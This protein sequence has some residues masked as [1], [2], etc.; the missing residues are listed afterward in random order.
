MYSE[1]K[2]FEKNQINQPA[3]G[4][5]RR[6][7]AIGA[8]AGFV[9]LSL[10]NL[11]F[12]SLSMAAQPKKGGKL[13][14]AGSYLNS[15][16]KSLKNAKHPYYG[17]E[18]RTR[19]TYNALTWVDE[20]LN[21][22]PE[23]A[24]DWESNQGQDVWEVTIREDVKFHDGRPLT[25]EDVIA[26]YNLHKD[27]KL[28]TSFVKK[29]VDKIEKVS[30]NKVRFFLKSP[31]SEFAWNLAEY[32]QAIM[33][34]AP[35]DEMGFLGI[36]SGPY[37]FAKIDV[38]RRV[39]YEA[40]EDYWGKGPYLDTLE[41]VNLPGTNPLNGYLSGQFDVLAAVDP[42]LINQL[43]ATPNTKIDIAKAGDQIMM[44]LPKYEGSPF[45]DKRVRQALTLALDREAIIRIVFGGKTGW[46]SND[47][48]MAPF[49]EDFL[50]KEPRNIPKA[51]QLLAEAGFENGIT[52]PTFYYAPYVPEITRVLSV[53]AESVKEAGITMKI[54]ERPMA[55]YRKW[56]VE[57]K[58][59]TTKHR[60]AMGPVG[61]RNPAMNLFRMARPTYNESGYWHPSAEGD[62]Y[63]E[64]YEKAMRT[65]DPI[66]RRNI[67]HD[68]QRILQNDVPA[69]FL[70][71]RRET[72][73]F[74]SNVHGLK[75]HSQH[76]S[77]RFNEVWKS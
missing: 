73:A 70:T 32:R 57:N 47:T 22:V 15:K 2:N 30:T 37:K 41:C 69:I 46:A 25:V 16:H 66:A 53:A 7:F 18:I 34:A 14:Y 4:I 9:S 44:V 36:G 8:G 60:F 1:K 39:I 62:R 71:G 67:Y 42:S 58:E 31:S 55:G 45:M 12:S 28:G 76:W 64:L 20:E 35:L 10:S 6:N 54:E 48:H 59:K 65:G 11:L 56:R 50:A 26:S 29:L 13:V 43:S 3:S 75:A 40:N 77:L 17:I 19:N 27:K 72:I 49:N 74:R 52:L 51:K 38:G 5:T 23:I 63:I 24:T 68:M 61:P 33:P 21:V